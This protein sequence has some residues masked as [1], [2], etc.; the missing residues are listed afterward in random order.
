M[1]VVVKAV[2]VSVHSHV[3]QVAGNVFHLSIFTKF[4]A[5]AL[6]TKEKCAPVRPWKSLVVN[7]LYPQMSSQRSHI[8]ILHIRV[9]SPEKFKGYCLARS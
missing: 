6:Y 8:F 5:F 2:V 9:L 3:V 4:Q 1:F 7:I